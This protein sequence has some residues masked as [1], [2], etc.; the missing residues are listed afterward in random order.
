[1][2]AETN[3]LVQQNQGQATVKTSSSNMGSIDTFE[4]NGHADIANLRQPGIF[5]QMCFDSYTIVTLGFAIDDSHQES[6]VQNLDEASLKVTATFPFVGGQVVIEGRTTTESGLYKIVPYPPHDGHSLVYRKDCT[7]LLPPYAEIAST[8]APFSKLDGNVLSPMPGFG[9]ILSTDIPWPVLIIQANLISGGLLLTF[10]SEH[11][12]LDMNGQGHLIKLFSTACNNQPFDPLDIKLGNEDPVQDLLKPGEK[13]IDLSV[14]K[15][16]SML[17]SPTPP[18]PPP[19]S[20]TYWRC[21]ASVLAQL[22]S[23]SRAYSTNDAFCAFYFQAICAARIALGVIKS[24]ELIHFGR[25]ANA[26]KP[27]GLTDKHMG[28][29]VAHADTLLLPTE[30]LAHIAAELRKTLGTIDGNWARSAISH[31]NN[32]ADKTTIFYGGMHRAGKDVMLSSWA[33]HPMYQLEFGNLGKPDFCRRPR[34]GLVPDLAYLMPRTREGDMDVAVCL[35]PE[36]VEALH[37]VKEWEEVMEHI[38]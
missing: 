2:R 20:W 28:H 21:P 6:I 10:A 13:S 29:A 3:I 32:T 26:R 30:S 11:N 33:H 17:A 23:S 38:G 14:M 7:S 9:A 27:M 35:R 31:I 8:K 36:E 15:R 19:C 1:M 25:A 5:G 34:M 37:R 22:K 16:P 4:M 12:A 24:D 18:A